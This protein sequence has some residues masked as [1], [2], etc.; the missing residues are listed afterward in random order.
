MSYT[1]SR[2]SRLGP[3]GSDRLDW[4]D[5]RT[6][7]ANECGRRLRQAIA[8]SKVNSTTNDTGTE[9][10]LRGQ[11]GE[12]LATVSRARVILNYERVEVRE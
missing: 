8:P 9:W 7:Y 12:L 6:R 3:G 4:Q 10:Q 5:A 2:M 11:D 1:C